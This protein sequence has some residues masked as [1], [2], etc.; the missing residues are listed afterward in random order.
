MNHFKEIDAM[1]KKAKLGYQ[2]VVVKLDMEGQSPVFDYWHIDDFYSTML[3]YEP[4]SNIQGTLLRLREQLTP[5]TFLMMVFGDSQM[6][7]Y[8]FIIP[9]EFLK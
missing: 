9:P 4:Y 2:Q 8:Q 1:L 3:K 7:A 5:Q 6:G